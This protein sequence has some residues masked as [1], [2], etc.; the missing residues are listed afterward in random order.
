MSYRRITDPSSPRIDT[1]SQYT[2]E[3]PERDMLQVIKGK[4]AGTK[5]SF[6]NVFQH[7]SIRDHV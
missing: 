2:R 3:R 7:A 6:D 5:S 1:V 4:T